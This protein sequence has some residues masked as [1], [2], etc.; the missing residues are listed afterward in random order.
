M[1]KL[2]KL[3]IIASVFVGMYAVCAALGVIVEWIVEKFTP[4]MTMDE[5]DEL[6]KNEEVDDIDLRHQCQEKTRKH[7]L[8]YVLGLIGTIGISA[9]IGKKVGLWCKDYYLS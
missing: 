8:A 6:Q 9:L 1:E 7:T 5:F 2:K 3:S 4:E